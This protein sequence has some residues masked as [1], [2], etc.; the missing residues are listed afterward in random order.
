MMAESKKHI[1]DES[2][3]KTL[4]SLEHGQQTR[5]PSPV[6]VKS[7]KTRGRQVAIKDVSSITAEPTRGW[8]EKE[9]IAR[10]VFT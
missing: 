6:E 1:Y 9:T 4:S 2:K 5:D 10:I 8:D 3:I 7:P